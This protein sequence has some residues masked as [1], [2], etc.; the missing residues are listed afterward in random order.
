MPDIEY[1]GDKRLL[2]PLLVNKTLEKYDP[3]LAKYFKKRRSDII[4]S[5][6]DMRNVDDYTVGQLDMIEEIMNRLQIPFLPV[7]LNY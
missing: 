5:I 6:E 4:H 3:N 1:E 7:V 2:L